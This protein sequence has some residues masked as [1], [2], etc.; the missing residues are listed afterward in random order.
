PLMIPGPDM[1]RTLPPLQWGL[2]V[3]FARRRRA[4]H[5]LSSLHVLYLLAELLELPLRRQ[6]EVRDHQVPRLGTR[7]V[8][9]AVHLLDQEVDPLADRSALP[10]RRRE[11]GEVALESHQLLG[12]VA[13]PGQPPDPARDPARA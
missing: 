3:P 2:G 8:E 1:P 9:L 10:E 11:R 12:D 4:E 7:R 5:T 6:H 13:P